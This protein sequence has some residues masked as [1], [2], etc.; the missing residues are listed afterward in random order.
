MTLQKA[1]NQVQNAHYF[2]AANQTIVPPNTLKMLTRLASNVPADS[3][4][5]EQFIY[6]FGSIE[7][8]EDKING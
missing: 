2:L 5:Y 3:P 4:F 1:R 6:S 7:E 8:I